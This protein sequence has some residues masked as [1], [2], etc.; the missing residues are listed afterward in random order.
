M[1]Y[2]YQDKYVYF[3]KEG[4]GSPIILL[5]GWGVDSSCFNDLIDSLKEKYQVFAIDLPGFGKS[6]EPS[7]YYML[8]DYVGLVEQFINDKKLINPILLGHSFGGRIA[9]RYASRHEV[10]KLILVDSAG[11]KPKNYVKI[12]LKIMIYKLKKKWYKLTKNV[13][14]YNALVKKSGSLDY[15]NASIPMKKTLSKVVSEYLEK[16][17]KKIKN[18]TLIIWGKNDQETPYRDALKL[19][20]KIKNSGLVSLDGV[21]HFPFIETKRIFNKIIREYLG[22]K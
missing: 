3:K 6:A 21:G 2:I 10:S 20:R 17:L 12:K 13:M 5:H 14:K 18:E 7:D 8:E 22:V 16:D 1:D 9:I 11:M 4:K 15:Q 19:N